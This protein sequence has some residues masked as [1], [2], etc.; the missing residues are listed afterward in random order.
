MNVGYAI[1]G[2]LL[3]AG[4]IDAPVRPR[5]L[6]SAWGMGLLGL[7]LLCAFGLFLALSGNPW[8]ALALALAG[9][10]LLGVA[11]NA[12]RGVLGEPLLFSDL[13][14]IGA[15]FRHPQFYFSA[16][17]DWQKVSAALVALALL[18]GLGALSERAP[19]PHLIGA[20]LFAVA[21][22]GLGASLHMALRQGLAP[23]PDAEADVARH[24][25][26]ACLLLYWMRW[27]ASH[28]P[29]PLCAPR[30]ARASATDQGDDEPAELVVIVQCESFADPADLFGEPDFALPEL[31][32]ARANAWQW[33]ELQ[34]SGFGAYTMRTE[35]AVLFGREEDALGFRRYDPFLSALGEASY[36]LPRR[37]GP[38]WRSLFVHPHDMRFYGR[39]RILPAGGFA[40]LIG[41]EHFAPPEPGAGRYVS[42]AA[43]AD[44]ILARARAACEPTLLYA[45]TIE[46]HGPWSAEGERGPEGL[47]A[48]YRRLAGK[49]DAMLARLQDGLRALG[50]PALLVFFGDHRPSIPGACLPGGARETPYVVL[51][52][53][54]DGK[55]LKAA[56]ADAPRDLTPAALHH[57]VLDLL[58]GP[59][60]G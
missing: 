15:L 32:A 45:V 53:D 38:D 16:L 11:S 7:A 47:V 28:D 42:D 3:L 18:A 5:R 44:Q 4:L 56:D 31:Q 26:I 24:G 25:V 35:Y 59:A 43:I 19:T 21:L 37:L 6:R 55:C 41:E 39:D 52:F 8:V 30:P 13:A 50:K 49:G 23:H 10:L 1:V 54:R 58:T 48:N 12:K 46:N 60:T 57:L 17:K 27:R 22:A 20:G 34:V 51:R 2:L 33:G 40:E 36:A 29:Q 14:L 9:Q